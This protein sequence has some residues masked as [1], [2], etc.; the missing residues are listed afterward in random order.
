MQESE[1]CTMIIEI[2][3]RNFYIF[4]HTIAFSL[5]ADMRNKKFGTNVHNE[6]N[7]NVLK[8]AGIY[9]ANNAGKTCLIKCIREI[10]RVILNKDN[11][12]MD[13]IFT[14]NSV[15]ELGVTFLSSGRKFSFDFKYDAE[16]EEYLYESFSE[17]IID[18]YHNEKEVFWL[19]K[20][21]VHEVY[22]CLDQDILPM[23]PIVSKN[24]LLYYTID[25]SK[26][27]LLDEMKQLL[28]EFAEKIDVINMNDIPI[29]HTIEL[30]KNKNHIQ[31]KIIDF[32]KNSDLYMDD[33]EYVNIDKLPIKN[34]D[35][36]KNRKKKYSTSQKVLWNKS[37]WFPH[38]EACLYPA[39]CLIPQEQRKLKPLP[40]MS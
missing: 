36:E 13:N 35:T 18:Q 34:D 11:Q 14:Q 26:F 1:A 9:G 7:F 21:T 6:N 17:L 10:Q 33:F 31:S 27:K 23:I 40:A 37:D 28:V 5:K 2:R 12:I 22:D 3:A 8:T 15:C 20:D 39:Y 16:K 38:I 25:T 4:E 32:I 30:M 29:N 24:N 19:K